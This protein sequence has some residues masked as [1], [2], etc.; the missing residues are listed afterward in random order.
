MSAQS[1]SPQVINAAGGGGTVGSSG[2]EVYYSI[3]EPFHLTLDNG[4]NIITQGFL[5]PDM[6]GRFGFTAGAFLTPAGCTDKAGGIIQ[7]TVEIPGVSDPRD[8][9]ISYHWNSSSLCSTG[10]TCSTV[11]NLPPGTYS[12]QVVARYRGSGN[13]VPNDTVNL[14]DL[15]IAGSSGPCPIKVY[16]GF[17]PNGDGVNDVF[18]IEN[19]GF[20]PGNS[21]EVYN[22]WG[23]PVFYGTHFNEGWD[24]SYQGHKADIGAYYWMI[25]ITD[26]FGK[27]QVMKGNSTLVR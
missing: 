19:I 21:V 23:Q 20:F 17:T 6:V 18:Y 24:G 1:V 27:E 4:T 22:R 9:V 3:G 7:V 25:S 12:V 15:V 10:D 5:Q 8:F 11:V 16:N 13:T 14:R 26:R 2:T